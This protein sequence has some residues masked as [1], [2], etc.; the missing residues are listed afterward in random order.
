MSAIISVSAQSFESEFASAYTK[1]PSMFSP[2]IILATIGMLL[3]GTMNTLSFKF[4]NKEDF[5]HGMVQSILTFIGEWLN[6]FIQGATYLTSACRRQKF[7]TM[8]EGAKN[9]NRKILMPTMLISLPAFL[10]SLGSSLQVVALLLIP[11]SINQM[12]RGGVIIFTCQLSRVFL[13]RKIWLHQ[14]FGIGLCTLGFVLVGIASLMHST[15]LT[16]RFT[17]GAKSSTQTVVGLCMILVSIVFQATQFVL[18]EKLMMK[19]EI[20]PLRMVG[21]EGVFGFGYC[22]LYLMAFS[23]FPCPEITMCDMTSTM[24]DPLSAITQIGENWVLLIWVIMT[25][26]SIMLFNLNGVYQTKN[27]SSIYRAFWDATRTILI[28]VFSIAFAQEAFIFEVFWIQVAG[29]ILLLLGNFVYNEVWVPPLKFMKN[30]VNAKKKFASKQSKKERKEDA[31]KR[32]T[33]RSLTNPINCP[34]DGSAN[35][36]SELKNMIEVEGNDREQGSQDFRYQ[37]RPAFNLDN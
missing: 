13:N 36:E 27:V 1:K 23:Y 35:K 9:T 33:T 14:V 20:E 32:N 22:F 15:D 34:S 37:T 16:S 31:K 18:E 8:I 3:S 30:S 29:F 2:I 6:L 12:L 11:A 26:L 24:E 7:S 5:R 4:Q 17:T 10:D 25:M 21:I 28:W 19:Y